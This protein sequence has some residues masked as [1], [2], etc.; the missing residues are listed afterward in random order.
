MFSFTT[1]Q[2]VAKAHR[3]K[4]RVQFQQFAIVEVAHAGYREHRK[5][6]FPSRRSGRPEPRSIQEDALSAVA[7]LGKLGCHSCS[8]G[9]A[10]KIHTLIVDRKPRMRVRPHLLRRFTLQFPRSIPRVIRADQLVSIFFCAI[11]H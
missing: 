11:L 4:L 6:C 9:K 5:S 1:A 3:F 10:C 8:A 2:E 7:K